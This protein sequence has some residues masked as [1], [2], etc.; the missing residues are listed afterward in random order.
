MRSLLV[1]LCS[2][3]FA[4]A[5]L[6]AMLAGCVDTPPEPGAAI[7]RLVVAWDPLAC[8]DPHRVAVELEGDSGA[9]ISA[10]TPCNLGGLTLDVSQFGSYRG[11]IYAWALDA[12]I[13]SVMPIEVT[14]DQPIVHLVMSTP[15]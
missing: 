2:P 15:Q 3:L 12:P 11:R 6:W 14:I 7:A 1:L 5:L 10:S 9:M 4:A 8:G 13:R